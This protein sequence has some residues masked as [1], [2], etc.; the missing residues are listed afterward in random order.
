MKTK[1]KIFHFYT[2]WLVENILTKI[3]SISFFKYKFFIKLDI[4]K[5]FY[6]SDFFFHSKQGLSL[7]Y[8][9]ESK[10]NLL[11]QKTKVSSLSAKASDKTKLLVIFEVKKF[12]VKT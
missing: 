2:K 1:N 8:G 4:K 7:L 6:I 12:Q 11:F 9:L 5:Y 3:F 10:E